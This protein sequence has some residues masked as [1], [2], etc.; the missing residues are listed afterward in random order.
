M[1]NLLRLA[2][3]TSRTDYEANGLEIKQA[4]ANDVA[5]RPVLFCFLLIAVDFALGP[6]QEVIIAGTPDS[7]DTRAML[8]MIHR[9]FLPNSVVMAISGDETPQDIID[10]APF[11]RDYKAINGRATAY[12]CTNYQ[13][14][15][16]TSQ[17]TELQQ[18]LR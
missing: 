5:K 13:C 4:F 14:N 16:P 17:V 12:V 1:L 2:R 6:V 11:L 7:D 9:L 10:I 15:R 3:L 18:L 8:S